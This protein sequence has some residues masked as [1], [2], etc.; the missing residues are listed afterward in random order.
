MVIPFA[1]IG[2][3]III[4][5]TS[6]KRAP[7]PTLLATLNLL[8]L[9][10]WSHFLVRMAV[11]ILRVL[12]HCSGV[13]VSLVAMVVFPVGCGVPVVLDK[14]RMAALGM[15]DMALV[16]CFASQVTRLSIGFFISFFK[17][18]LQLYFAFRDIVGQDV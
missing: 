3:Y 2:S 9:F 14:L 12:S 6:K 8:T 7:F 5:T 17:S 11:D 18:G 10:L 13:N 15:G 4:F 16:G 1:V